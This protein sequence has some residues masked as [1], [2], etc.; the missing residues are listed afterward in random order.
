MN[1][2]NLHVMI[3][4]GGIG[5]RFWPL[6]TT[7]KPKQFVD[8]LGIGKSL[9]QVTF[10]RMLTCVETENT[11][12]LTNK[13]YRREV[14]NQLPLLN[15][16]QILC[17]P[18][19]KN[20]APCIA[21]AAA[22]C[23][24]LNPNAILI[25]VPS[26]HIIL[27]TETF[28]ESVQ[29]AVQAAEEGAI[30]TLG[31]KPTR[32]DTGYGYIEVSKEQ[33]ESSASSKPV[34][35]FCEKPSPERARQFM[36]DGNFLWNAGI[37]VASVQTLKEAFNSYAPVIHDAFF[38]RIESRP[39]P[40]EEGWVQ[41]A[42]SEVPSISFDFAVMEKSENIKVVP[43]TFDW[44]DLGTWGSLDQLA[45]KDQQGNAVVQGNAHLLA[46]HNCLVHISKEKH[47]FLNGVQDLIIGESDGRIFIAHKDKEP[48]LKGDFEHICKENKDFPA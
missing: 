46:T 33:M 17:E 9:L 39:S 21:Y 10:E 6:S 35:R 29:K 48:E 28:K 2:H 5:S 31:I 4:A 25:I 13:M 11:W 12:V 36:E 41:K 15:P 30:V 45:T 43:S 18:E 7:A 47:I 32:P 19:R 20:T 44:S 37:F 34:L 23:W 22:K 38:E 42:F 40:D 14:T 24:H 16:S 3:M 26:D 1:K 8:V 27:N